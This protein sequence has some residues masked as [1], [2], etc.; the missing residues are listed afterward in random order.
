M[1]RETRDILSTFMNQG[2]RIIS[3]PVIL[4]LIPLY[5]SME[6][7]GCWYTFTS[8]AALSIFADLG[9][10]AIVLQ[11][12][13]HE[14][15]CLRFMPNKFIGGSKEQINRLASFFRFTVR[16]GIRAILVVFPLIS[17]GGYFFLFRQ[18]QSSSIG[19]QWGWLIYS[20][21]SGIIFFNN[22]LL[23]FFEGCNSVAKLQEIRFRM[24]VATSLTM[25]G[26][27]FTDAGLYALVFSGIVSA[28]SGI[29]FLYRH[30][31]KSM[32]QLW[33]ASQ[34]HRYDWWPEFSSL[35]WRYALSWCSGYFGL[36]AYTPV[37][38]YFWG[39]EAAGKVGLSMAMWTAGLGIANCWMTAVVP[40]LNMMV[41]EKVWDRLDQLFRKSFWRTIATMLAGGSGFLTVYAA[42]RDMLPIWK[43]ILSLEGMMILFLCWLG[44][45]VINSWAT[46][47]RAYKK[48]PLMV[49]SIIFSLYVFGVTL[50][51]TQFFPVDYMFLGFL[52]AMVWGIPYVWRIYNCQKKAH[53]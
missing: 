8:L 17:I 22:I 23:T 36:S 18:L 21:A 20:C 32:Y 3:G 13:A 46:Y 15:T 26:C 42:T 39:P 19:W 29:F 12:S 2:W 44:Q 49:Y 40:R 47:L 45:L 28:G 27:L 34:S 5:L 16:W 1:R 31:R 6:E 38:F 50:V 24:A 33:R 43:R 52:S 11:F 30:F 35:M 48:E 9:F 41:E 53:V 51:C 4:F 10:G 25:I 37:A 7:Q 14:F